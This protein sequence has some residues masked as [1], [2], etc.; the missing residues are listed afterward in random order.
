MKLLLLAT[1]LFVSLA[2][3]AS[4]ASFARQS[5]FLSK[6][7]VTE[8]DTVLIHAVVANESNVK[9]TGDV[10]LKD[11][12]TK[13]GSVAVAIAPGGAQAVSVSWKPLAGTHLVTAQLTAEDETVVES[14]SANFTINEKQKPGSTTG[15]VN[16][17]DSSSDIKNKINEILPAAAP[18]SEPVF[19]SLDSARASAASALDQGITWAKEK[20]GGKKPGEV[21]GASSTT[22]GGIVD[23]I[24]TLLATILLYIFSIL[25]FVVGNAGIFYPAF[26][27][28]FFYILWRTYKRMRRPAYP[29]F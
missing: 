26:A 9:F 5:L 21:L 13:V 4:A 19:A 18:V 14:Q 6:T 17:V 3:S 15:T 2:S 28:L 1:L 22:Q 11:G 29:E 23:T 27:I 25:R 7:P 10:V 24:W 16:G 20:T 8:G 12:E